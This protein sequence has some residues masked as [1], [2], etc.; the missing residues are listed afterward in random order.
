MQ[1][2]PFGNYVVI[3]ADPRND[4]TKS[5][6]LIPKDDAA[7]QPSKGTVI[8]FGDGEHVPA[9]LAIGQRVVFKS[10][11]TDEIADGDKKFFI[12]LAN[13]VMAVIE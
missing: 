11:A 6:I 5:G 10:Y 2:K 9:S 8:A 3:E 1:L 12:L 7:P 13:D 4:R